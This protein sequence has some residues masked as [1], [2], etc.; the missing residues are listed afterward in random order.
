MRKRK[1]MKLASRG[2]R[3]GAACIDAV[4]PASACFIL[5]VTSIVEALRSYSFSQNFGYDFGTPGFGYGYGYGRA[6]T[7]G[8]V[9]AII[10]AILLM[11]VY[12][13][14]QLIFFN[15]STSLGKAAL[16]LQVV[17]SKNGEAVGF[18]KM[19]FREVL[20]KKASESVL[21]LGYIW[22][23]I[24]DKNRGWHDKILDT[25]VVDL[26]ESAALAGKP[27]AKP[28]AQNIEVSRPTPKSQPV[29]EAEAVPQPASDTDLA[30]TPQSDQSVIEETAVPQPEA[31]VILEETEDNEQK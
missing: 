28:A 5:F 13:V 30:A 15:R 17:S 24:D 12:I 22:I 14:V 7:G 4:I 19:L 6:V 1:V 18:W 11:I 8:A 26:K 25:Y 27:A 3:F 9:A 2:K 21:L 20:V 16:G 23:L 31:K 29:S 10:I